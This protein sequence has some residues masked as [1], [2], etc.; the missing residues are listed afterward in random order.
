M[1]HQLS[2]LFFLGRRVAA[3]VIVLLLGTLMAGDMGAYRA[4]GAAFH[5]QQ[6]MT[7][8]ASVP[9]TALQPAPLSPP[10]GDLDPTFGNN[11]QVV[12]A[13][14]SGRS[15]AH[16][17][18]L[19][20]DGKI[21]AAGRTQVGRGNNFD[22]GLTRYDSNGALDASFGSGGLVTTDFG[23]GW[24][25]A[26][27]V[28]IQGD[29]KI[30]AAG[31]AGIGSFPPD[32]A[33]V[34]YNSDGTL[35]ASFGSGG[36][37]TTDFGGMDHAYAV[38]IQ[39]DS[40]IVAVGQARDGSFG[41]AR[42]N[43][44]GTLDASFGNGG[45]VT[46]F[47]GGW[48]AYAAA[49]VIQ[50]DGKIVA[51]GHTDVGGFALA[52]YNSDGTLD[53]TFGSVGLVTTSFEDG[54][55]IVSAVD[56]QSDG[57]IVAAG[58]AWGGSSDDFALARYNSDGTLDASFGSGGKVTT[59]FESWGASVSAVVIQG[60]GKIVAAGYA[61]I[62]GH[63]DFTLARYSS[64]GTLDA[65]FGSSGVVT[66]NFGEEDDYAYA[67]A[68]Q[69]DGKIVAA[70]RAWVNDYEHFALARYDSNGA[71]DASF[72][73][74][75]QVTTAI[76]RKTNAAYAVAVQSDGKI[77]AA[78][79]A[80]I[81]HYD[82]PVFALARYNSD[83]TLDGSFGSGGRVT[84][85]WEGW[86][87][88]ARAVALQDDGKIVA[89]GHAGLRNNTDF[90]LARY[91][92]DGTLDT[93]FADG[94]QVTTDFG[95]K[96]D[97]AYA[98]AI[99]SDGKIVAA[100][101][102]M[103]GFRYAFALARY[104]GDGAL[105]T[106]FGSGGKVTTG[107]EGG[108][109]YASG[110]VIQSDGKIVVAGYGWDSSHTGFALAR[111]HSD[112]TLDTSFGSGGLVTTPI[113]DVVH[114]AHD[115]AIQ[116]DGKIVAAGR[117]YIGGLID[118]ALTRYNSDGSLDTS[119]GDGGKVTTDF[120]GSNDEAYAV[121]IHSDGK[122]VVAGGA[123]IGGLPHFALA[124][125]NSEGTLDV[126]FGNGGQVTTSFE[127]GSAVANALAIQSD[128]RIVAAGSA[129]ADGL[130]HFTLA[131]YQVASTS[132]QSIADG[133][134]ATLEGVSITNHS[135]APCDLTVTRHPIPPGGAP[136]DLGELP[137]LWQLATT[138]PSYNFDM[139]FSYT[140]TELL[141]GNN[142]TEA[143]LQAYR[144]SAMNGPY[145]PAASIVDTN[146]NTVAVIGVTQLSWWG[147]ISP[148]QLYLPLL[149]RQ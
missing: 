61:Y 80:E 112:G 101:D 3:S 76:G 73:N 138:C 19:Q 103:I 25:Y 32:F 123:S 125:Y 89:A 77:V 115:L 52:R 63:I 41:L 74:G 30:V 23:S 31:Q 131:R 147:L 108:G 68:I 142:V 13:M 129:R 120:G 145:S 26:Y 57:K 107:L 98:A 87:N 54:G 53:T 34:R 55:G 35:D 127:S 5:P 72:G 60:D 82:Y 91:N 43:S 21:V 105:D 148:R 67:A 10:V 99:Q 116:S 149:L 62:H 102:A 49:V 92:S 58:H 64:D 11:G 24:D 37:V 20:H 83:S 137:V 78:G 141:F 70:G 117:G 16:G 36:K 59:A 1:P 121:S 81:G 69:D 29:G 132:S 28:A 50:S 75:G 56:I 2:K 7:G 110:V 66:T 86:T 18:A 79:Y 15:Y 14:G 104:N 135:G 140:D 113:G 88:G 94:G 128:G 96:N 119:F 38:A 47:F 111:Y 39:S 126:S 8:A 134:S 139:R 45:K 124:R 100:G 122:I 48:Y 136:A 33:L 9:V 118:F 109:L 146:A 133:A 27:A 97:Q 114:A 144:A 84:T 51:A 12:T 106:S 22:F 65:S 93:S 95:G 143:D 6:P 85:D 44:D 46:T 42:Y 40:K 130:P 71:L 90:A 17:V 4:A